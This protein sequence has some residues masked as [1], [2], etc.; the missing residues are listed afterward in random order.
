MHNM[1]RPV[2]LASLALGFVTLIAVSGQQS[3]PL[4][5]QQVKN[6]L[7]MITG[8]GGNIGVRVST[9]GVVLVDNKFDRNHDAIM[10]AVQSVTSQP[11][12]YVIGTHH[13]GDHM[14]G[15]PSFSTHADIIGHQN[16]RTNMLRGDQPAPPNIVF[17]DETA[18]FLGGVEVRAYH[19]GQGHTNGDAVVYFPDLRTIHGGDLLHGTAPFIDYANGGSSR[20]WITTLD[21][22]LELDWDTAI[23]GHGA[24]MTRSDVQDF[25]NQMVSVRT[26]MSELIGGGVSREDA[27]TRLRTNELSWT[28][29]DEGLFMRRSI[30][31]FYD[32]MSAER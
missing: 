1:R 32:E 6:N 24:V 15:N 23:P 28:V 2:A 3:E 17:S 21:A 9:D 10:S 14:G 19:F 5:I 20:A 30:P 22:L 7:Y 13:H 26:R 4:D 11:I 29:A 27:P 16:N 12:T 18:V 8:P 25:R 31:G